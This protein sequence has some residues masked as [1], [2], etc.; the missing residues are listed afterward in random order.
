MNRSKKPQRTE[1][2]NKLKSAQKELSQVMSRSPKLSE[3]AKYAELHE[4]T[5]N[6]LLRELGDIEENV[7]LE[8]L[9]D[10]EDLAYEQLEMDSMSGDLH[11]LLN[12]L[13][14]LQCRVLRMRYGMDG[15]EP[16]SLTE[17]GRLLGLTR[18][19]VKYLEHD[20]L[21]CLRTISDNVSEY[22]PE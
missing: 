18:K 9:V 3:L 8:L 22:F 12:Q 5:I 10:D 7:L 17:I 16:K 14:D 21:S 2:F 1:M 4:E 15:D 6:D 19:Q 11:T 20:G 13:P